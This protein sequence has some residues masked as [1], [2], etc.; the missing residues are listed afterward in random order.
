L[1]NIVVKLLMPVMA[2]GGISQASSG[3][4]RLLAWLAHRC[5]SIRQ[6][7]RWLGFIIHVRH[8]RLGRQQR[9]TM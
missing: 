4:Q 8:R 3:D 6:A 9:T 1:P 5:V 2:G 7:H